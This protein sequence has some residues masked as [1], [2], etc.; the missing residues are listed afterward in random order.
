MGQGAPGGVEVGWGATGRQEVCQGCYQ[1]AVSWPTAL[2][3]V[4]KWAGG[5]HDRTEVGQGRSRPGDLLSTSVNFPCHQGTF[6][7][8]P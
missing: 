2:V 7:E 1:W 4:R 3:A 5:A 6:C 8:L